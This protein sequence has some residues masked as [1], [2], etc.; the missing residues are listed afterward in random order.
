MEILNFS[1]NGNQKPKRSSKSR[2]FMGIG[3]IAASVGLSSTLAANISINA[4]PVEFGQG[5]AQTVACSG[6]ESVIV[7]PATSFSNKG[8][9]ISTIFTDADSLWLSV[10]STVNI[11][12]G[13]IV[14]A[15]DGWIDANTVVT[16]IDGDHN[17]YISKDP[18]GSMPL[19][20]VPVTFSVSRGTPK[21]LS[22]TDWGSFGIYD[23]GDFEI[24]TL[25]LTE[26]ML[27][28]GPGIAADTVITYVEPGFIETSK[29]NSY[30]GGDLTFANSRSVTVGSF[31]LNDITVSNIPD[32]C[33]GKVFTIKLY[34][35]ESSEPIIVTNFN[36]VGYG[37]DSAI[38]VYW[39]NGYIN[40]M[41]P[42]Y[43]MI[44]FENYQWFLDSR[45]FD[46][47]CIDTVGT[48]LETADTEGSDL[49]SNAFKV[50]LPS[51][52]NATSVYK[53]TLESQDDA[54]TFTSYPEVAGGGTS[55]TS[56]FKDFFLDYILSTW[57]V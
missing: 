44:H 32:T 28:S 13:M 50:I 19:G 4:G 7:T 56:S 51:P 27:I 53:I 31:K 42:S 9:D 26:G 54:S 48:C 41:P 47:E 49:P 33:N 34:D 10:A 3:I 29:A 45:D 1:N 12:V 16:G 46:G 11:T 52:V 21:K 23:Y 24:D 25:G 36:D 55:F 17:V 38:Q 5:V 6:D 14:S 15:G 22:P 57:N 20:G 43:A 35:N 2:A 30:S 40:Q 37:E 39:G 8:A 18:H